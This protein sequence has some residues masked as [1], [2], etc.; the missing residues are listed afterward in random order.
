MF[1]QLRRPETRRPL[2]QTYTSPAIIRSMIDRTTDQG[3]TPERLIDPGTG[4][5]GYLLA[6][7]QR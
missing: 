4:S 2:G 1:A 3:T 7:G 5:A 6:A